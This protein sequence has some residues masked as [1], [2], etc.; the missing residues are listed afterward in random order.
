MKHVILNNEYDFI[1]SIGEAC[2]CSSTLRQSGLQFESYPLD[3]LYGGDIRTRTEL[4][5]NNFDNFINKEDLQFGGQ[6]KF[7]QPCDIYA[8]ISNKIVFNHDFPYDGNLDV[9][10]S[11]V[12]EKY[13]R[14]IKR[15]YD[16]IEKAN[17]ILI[18]YM[19]A[20]N[21]LK[22]NIFRVKNV[23]RDC[24]SK[25]SSKWSGKNICLLY[26]TSRKPLFFTQNINIVNKNVILIQFDYRHSD[27][28]TEPH[29]VNQNL[30]CHF[31]RNIKLSKNVVVTQEKIND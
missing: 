7:P 23:L 27:L 9:D 12:K 26:L 15:L 17:K 20:P 29:V 31:F 21:T 10:Y 1:F 6:R 28:T 30:L 19:E 5:V 4:L 11:F 24:Y 16:N 2:S 22:K 14:R 8:N 25:I 3:W 18:V 13:D